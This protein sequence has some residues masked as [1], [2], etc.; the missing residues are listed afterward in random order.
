MLT[1]TPLATS[2]RPWRHLCCSMPGSARLRASSSTARCLSSKT[3]ATRPD[4]ARQ[5]KTQPSQSF[6]T[7]CFFSPPLN[8]RRPGVRAAD[9]HQYPPHDSSVRPPQTHT[10]PPPRRSPALP[11]SMRDLAGWLPAAVGSLGQLPSPQVPPR[12]YVVFFQHTNHDTS[13]HRLNLNHPLPQISIT[14]PRVLWQRRP[15]LH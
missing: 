3:P 14:C 9:A 11:A 12:R 2:H 6:S 1:I 5:H 7:V 10:F 8:L 4:G 15:R 13:A